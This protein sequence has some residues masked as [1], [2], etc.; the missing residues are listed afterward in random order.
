MIKSSI[1]VYMCIKPTMYA[2][3]CRLYIFT[4]LYTEQTVGNSATFVCNI[5][6]GD[7]LD[8]LNWMFYPSDRSRDPEMLE[9][10]GR[11]VIHKF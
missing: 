5:P 8:S 1:S 10:Q 4:C 6:N 2:R 9:I 11:Y 3:S 7:I